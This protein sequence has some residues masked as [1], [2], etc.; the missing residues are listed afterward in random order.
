[1]TIEFDSNL[2]LS[3]ADLNYVSILDWWT[4]TSLT[5]VKSRS[6]DGKK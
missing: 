5:R 4:K 1:M 2:N 3:V 6:K